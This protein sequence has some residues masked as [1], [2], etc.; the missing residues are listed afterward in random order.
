MDAKEYA[1]VLDEQG[2]RR[3]TVAQIERELNA[4][5]YRLDRTMDCRGTARFM[6]GPFAGE[7]FPSL[8]TGIAQSDNRVSAFN[9][10]ARRDANYGRLKELRGG[11]VYALVGRYVLEL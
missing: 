9:V 5:G 2:A 8:T 6:T 1:K 4:I 3:L 10:N 11:A 7:T